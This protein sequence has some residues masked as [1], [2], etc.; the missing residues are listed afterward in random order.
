MPAPRATTGTRAS[1]QM[2]MIC[3]HL[4]FIRRQR[5]SKWD[6]AVCGKTVAFVGP[7]ILDVVQQRARRQHCRQ[8]PHQLGFV[9]ER[10]DFRIDDFGFAHFSL[11]IS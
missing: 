6:R 7:Q 2:R 9:R 5:D 4:L 8:T 3:A 1:K 10:L 11:D